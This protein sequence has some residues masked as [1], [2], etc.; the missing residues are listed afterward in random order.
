MSTASASEPSF[1][2]PQHAAEQPATRCLTRAAERTK[3]PRGNTL[4]GLVNGLGLIPRTPV[5]DTATYAAELV[6]AY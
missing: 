3:G 2:P 5:F 6:W 4:H 1:L